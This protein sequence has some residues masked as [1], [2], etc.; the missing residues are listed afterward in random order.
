MFMSHSEINNSKHS[1][2]H[3]VHRHSDQRTSHCCRY[4]FAEAERTFP[5][6]HPS[7][8]FPIHHTRQARHTRHHWHS[9]I[10]VDKQHESLYENVKNVVVTFFVTKM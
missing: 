8:P 2:L 7:T 5:R 3:S 10:F 1:P 9:E 4:R 6:H